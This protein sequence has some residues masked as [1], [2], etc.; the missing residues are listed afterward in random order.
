MCV[1]IY[2]CSLSLCL[3]QCDL[4]RAIVRNVIF[5]YYTTRDIRRKIYTKIF[6]AARFDC[7]EKRK[8]YFFALIIQGY[9]IQRVNNARAAPCVSTLSEDRIEEGKKKKNTRIIYYFPRFANIMSDE[10]DRRASNC[11]HSDQTWDKMNELIG[12]IDRYEW[13]KDTP[14]RFAVKTDSRDGGF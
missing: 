3:I 4:K 12:D 8:E 7:F 14:F 11:V 2:L 10:S 6:F 5:F 1:Y 13:I 9:G